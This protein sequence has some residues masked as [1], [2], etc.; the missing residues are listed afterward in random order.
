MKRRNI[1]E[2]LGVPENI[3]I[4]AI[5]LYEYIVAY[6]SSLRDIDSE[7][8]YNIEMV[9]DFRISDM[10]LKKVKLELELY[11]MVGKPITLV[12]M[13][14]AT[15]NVIN[16]M[17]QMEA[18]IREDETT[19]HIE[20]V[21]P[22]EFEDIELI[23]FFKNNKNYLISIIA[24]E[25]KHGYDIFKKRTQSLSKRVDYFIFSSKTFGSLKPL[26]D[27][28]FNSYYI[29]NIEN[30]VRP[31]ELAAQIQLEKIT[32]KEFYNFFVGNKI[33][34]TLKKIGN[35]YYEDL[36]ESL[37]GYGSD[38]EEILE[39]VDEKYDT[40]EESID[41]ILELFYINIMNWKNEKM[42][43]LIYP[44]GKDNPLFPFMRTTDKDNF[45]N[46]YF[47]K[48]GKFDDNY[49]QFYKKEERYQKNTAIKMIKKLGKLYELTYQNIMKENKSIWNWELYKEIKGNKFEITKTIKNKDELISELKKRI[50]RNI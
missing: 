6:L 7:L 17:F 50:K 9:G 18:R 21:V 4:S 36:K 16:S 37:R 10:N 31:T 34:Q 5:K 27:F 24:H 41:R 30:L 49:E 39:M 38:I 42:F 43:D 8:K 13:G 45:L 19:L 40:I 47:G 28:L 33:F 32:P 44:I 14:Q 11:K 35:F 15:D 48:T 46:D 23:N 2:A 29:H 12:S 25:L 26:N 22:N 3:I 20:I 1:N